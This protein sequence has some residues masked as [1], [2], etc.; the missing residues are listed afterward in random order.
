MIPKTSYFKNV[1][2]CFSNNDWDIIRNHIY[3]RTENRC[4]CCGVK[5]SKYLEAHERWIY[6]YETNTQKLIRIIALCKL[7]HQATHYG[8]SKIKKD[9]T[10]IN[11]HIKKV[12]KINDEE[13]KEHIN[14]SYEIWK[15]RNKIKWIID[16]SIISNSGFIII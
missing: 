2:S 4:E 11:E 7:C 6:D 5:R 9:I 3:K 15:E 10:K 13:L 16:L 12:R 14:K 8:H 1:R